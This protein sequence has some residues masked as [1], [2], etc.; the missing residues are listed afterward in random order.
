MIALR[1]GARDPYVLARLGLYDLALI[2]PGRDTLAELGRDIAR[3]ALG[4]RIDFERWP[5]H[6]WRDERILLA[7]AAAPHYPGQVAIEIVMEQTPELRLA[8]AACQLAADHEE[9]AR[10][11]ASKYGGREAEAIRAAVACK[12]GDA[13]AGA[14]AINAMFGAD[15]LA[16]PLR[17]NAKSCALDN[18]ESPRRDPEHGPMVS[19]I[20]PIHNDAATITTAL[21]SLERQSWRSLDIL[22]V[23]DRSSD[24]G[25]AIVKEHAARDP[26]IRLIVNQ[27]EP[28]VYGARNTGILD[29]RGEFVAFLDADDWS[30]AERIARQMAMLGAG[31]VVSIANHIRVDANGCPLAPRVFPLVRPVPITMALRHETA[32]AAGPFEEVATGADS[33][34]LGRLGMLHGRSAVARDPAVLLVARWRPGSLSQAGEGGLFGGERLAYRADWMFRHAGYFPPAVKR[35]R[36]ISERSNRRAG[37]GSGIPSAGAKTGRDLGRRRPQPA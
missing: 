1:G 32:Y 19:V 21:R 22:V 25:P 9:E 26:R 29:A 33:E 37:R 16:S 18:F 31:A 20:V 8:F 28:G 30:P 15:D 35:D 23:D 7:R 3:A 14:L 12:R 34:M 36:E 24:S 10:R 2:A 17:A 13:R 11:A 6:R 4:E 27:R 5:P